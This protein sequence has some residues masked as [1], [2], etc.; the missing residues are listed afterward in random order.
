M[1]YVVPLH[2]IPSQVINITLSGQDCDITVYQK[3]TGLYF[4][5]SVD[6]NSIVSCVLC[7]DRVVLVTQAYLGF[8]GNLAFLDTQGNTDPSYD[9]LGSR[10]LLIYTGVGEVVA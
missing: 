10:Y 6:G 9:G 1:S 5:L 3:T 7:R 8:I 2:S 4:D